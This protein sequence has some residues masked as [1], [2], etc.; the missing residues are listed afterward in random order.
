[1]ATCQTNGLTGTYKR[2]SSLVKH[3]DPSLDVYAEQLKAISA[4]HMP[5]DE[6]RYV[7]YLDREGREGSLVYPNLFDI[8]IAHTDSDDVVAQKITALLSATN[9]QLV[10]GKAFAGTHPW[11]NLV[12]SSASAPRLSDVILNNSDIKA[13]L[14]DALRWRNLDSEAKYAHVFDLTLDAPK[15]QSK[16]ILPDKKDVYEISYLGGQG[17][18]RNFAFGFSPEEKTEVPDWVKNLQALHAAY[19]NSVEPLS[20]DTPSDFSLSAAEISALTNGGGD[21]SGQVFECGDP[22]G[23]VIWKW[24]SAIQCWL[25][26]L[27]KTKWFVPKID[28]LFPE[29]PSITVSLNGQA[30]WTT[31]TKADIPYTDD[32]NNGVSDYVENNTRT[33]SLSSTLS[34]TI[35]DINQ[36]VR[37]DA[38]LEN[39]TSIINDDGSRIDLFITEIDDLDTKKKYYPTD[40]NWNQIQDE[41][42]NISGSPTL[43]DGHV[44]W[45][46][47]GKNN[48]RA[49]IY[50]ES[51]IYSANKVFLSSETSILLI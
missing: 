35:I 50:T 33:L 37:V 10:P 40:K 24:L 42:I 36:T 46:M 49:R 48:H 16:L 14:I 7:S 21:T 17:D 1:M 45:I 32:N 2:I 26:N 4:P 28:D 41:Y 15:T 47:E 5:V 11:S 39:A 31:K 38:T 9:A 34:D 12:G 27:L 30:S 3:A 20:S 18:A 6:E 13:G 23:V 8:S 19:N 43:K 22:N 51:R 44:S 29:P 25:A